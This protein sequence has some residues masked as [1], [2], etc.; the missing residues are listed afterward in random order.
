MQ[1]SDCGEDAGPVDMAGALRWLK[2]PEEE[3]PR[4]LILNGSHPLKA[5][6][7]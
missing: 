4:F 1:P 7:P 5:G 3:S 2:N 6:R